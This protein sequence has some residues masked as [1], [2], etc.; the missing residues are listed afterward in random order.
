MVKVNILIDTLYISE[1]KDLSQQVKTAETNLSV[2]QREELQRVSQL[3][4]KEK[5]QMSELLANEQTI[6]QKLETK[7]RNLQS[8][9]DEFR[10]K[11][12]KLEKIP[13]IKLQSLVSK[14]SAKPSIDTSKFNILLVGDRNVGK[15]T[16]YHRFL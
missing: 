7:T 1:L 11:F 10:D 12:E 15:T 14:K 6:S 2:M 8:Q 3:L 9:I 5:T 4:R 16:F 13:D